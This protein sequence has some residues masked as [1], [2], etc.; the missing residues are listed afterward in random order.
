MHRMSNLISSRRNLVLGLA[1]LGLT[2]CGYS[3]Y[4]AAGGT[5]GA[6]AP[7][8]VLDPFSLQPVALTQ[9]TSTITTGSPTGTNTGLGSSGGNGNNGIGV[10]SGGTIFTRPPTRN[11]FRPP[12]RSPFVPGPPF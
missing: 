12:V 4:A 10:D 3:V 11:P 7:K 5:P 8:T 6:P 2:A 1:A 9:P